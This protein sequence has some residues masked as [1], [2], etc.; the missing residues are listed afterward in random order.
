MVNISSGVK[1]KNGN[2]YPGLDW[3]FKTQGMRAG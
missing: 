1:L 3:S 2:K